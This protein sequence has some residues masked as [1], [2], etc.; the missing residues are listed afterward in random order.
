MYRC[1]NI[2]LI[3]YCQNK[4]TQELIKASHCTLNIIIDQF[5][6]KLPF[7]CGF[8]K[9]IIV[10]ILL[11]N[12]GIVSCQFFFF[13]VVKKNKPYLLYVDTPSSLVPW[14]SKGLVMAQDMD[15]VM[16][17]VFRHVVRPV[18]VQ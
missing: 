9:N 1:L 8:K 14:S 17:L 2:N 15:F 6:K 12:E 16:P 11:H 13:A 10:P 4:H 18:P 5:V 7:L 3:S